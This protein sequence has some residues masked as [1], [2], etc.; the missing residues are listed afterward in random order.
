MPNTVRELLVVLHLSAG[1]QGLNE[2]KRET[3]VIQH[4]PPRLVLVEGEPNVIDRLR[5]L[6]GVRSVFRPEDDMGEIGD[7]SEHERLFVDGWRLRGQPKER[8]GDGLPWDAPGYL[9]PDPP[10]DPPPRPD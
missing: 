9:P 7:L 10:P 2:V 6:P 8:P 5:E 3:T 1:D 4:V